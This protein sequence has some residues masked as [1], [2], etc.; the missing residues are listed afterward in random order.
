[1]VFSGCYSLTSITIPNS[2]TS[3]GDFAFYSCKILTSITIPNS[4][5]NIGAGLF[6]RCENLTSIT[7]QWNAPPQI[8]STVFGNF[9]S[10][11]LIVPKGTKASYEAAPVWKDFGEIKEE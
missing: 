2:V 9:A 8:N 5:I 4:V 11:T 1:V 7:V 10:S 3:I 6:S